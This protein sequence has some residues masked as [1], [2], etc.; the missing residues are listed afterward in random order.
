[1]SV[2]D[3]STADTPEVADAEPVE[4]GEEKA[5]KSRASKGALEAQVREIT[6]LYASGALTMHPAGR[7]LT[8]HNI[9]VY[10]ALRNDLPKAP[11]AGAVTANLDRWEKIGF[12]V[13]SHEKPKSFVGYTPEATTVGLSELKARHRVGLSEAKK[14]EK[15]AAK[16]VAAP[17]PAEA[18]PVTADE[19]S[20]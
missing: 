8:P 7:P 15:E 5:A 20:A 13:L 6:D 16:S 2:T 12:A 19:I 4:A 9:A 1:M 10:I 3:T 18:H 11:S 14:A 17:A